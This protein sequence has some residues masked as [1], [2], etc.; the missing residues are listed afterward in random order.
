MARS[1]TTTIR[2]IATIVRV[3]VS[4]VNSSL[5]RPSDSSSRWAKEEYLPKVYICGDSAVRH[6]SRPDKFQEQTSTGYR[7]GEQHLAAG[8]SDKENWGEV[9]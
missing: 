6:F 5:N 8:F 4:V 3:K 1:T 2:I 7:V 9:P